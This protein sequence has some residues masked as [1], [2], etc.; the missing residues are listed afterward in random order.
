M[1]ASVRGF[2]RKLYLQL[3]EAL[4]PGATV[5]RVFQ[6]WLDETPLPPSRF[7]PMVMNGIADAE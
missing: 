7:L 4:H 6:L 1:L 2:D 3:A 5:P